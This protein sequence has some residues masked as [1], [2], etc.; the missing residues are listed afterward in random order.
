MVNYMSVRSMLALRILRE[1][2]TKSVHFV[3]AYTHTDVKSEIFME[4][5]IVFGVEGDHPK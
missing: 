3:L 2:H 4:I 5:P 1:L